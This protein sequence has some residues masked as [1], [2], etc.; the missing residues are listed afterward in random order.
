MPA[1]AHMNAFT[2]YDLSG[3]LTSDNEFRD[4]EARSAY[5]CQVLRQNPL[6]TKIIRM[7]D[8]PLQSLK[9]PASAWLYFT[10]T[11]KMEG[12][13]KFGSRWFTGLDGG[14]YKWKPASRSLHCYDENERLLAVYEYGV[15]DVY[16]AKLDIKQGAEDMVIE[17]IT[18]LLLNRH[19]IH[20]SP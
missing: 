12:Y 14:K 18:T 20:R 9:D 2:L 17:I 19:N 6:S 11:D 7:A 1:S 10:S 16:F 3:S 13:I 5:Y 4:S 8:W 15:D